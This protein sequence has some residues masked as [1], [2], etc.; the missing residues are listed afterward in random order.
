MSHRIKFRSPADKDELETWEVTDHACPNCACRSV[1]VKF[2][3]EGYERTS[4]HLCTACRYA[5]KLSKLN[6]ANDDDTKRLDR[7]CYG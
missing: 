1:Y 4:K 7:I 6:T 3:S 2:D 5:F